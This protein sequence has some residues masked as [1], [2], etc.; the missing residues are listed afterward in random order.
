MISLSN[1]A[2]QYGGQVLFDDASFQLNPGDKAGLVGPNGSGKTT[3]FRLIMGEEE[4]T[5]GAVSRPKKLTVGYF[6]QDVGD[7]AGRSVLAETVAGAGELADLGEELGRLEGRM[8]EA[9]D[10][11]DAVI[12]RYGEVQSRFEELGGYELESRARSILAGLGLKD[13]QVDEDIGRLSGGWKMRVALARILL[14]QPDALLLDEPT[15]YLDLESILWFEGFLRDYR[16]AVLMTCHDRD[17][18]NRVVSRIVEIDGGEIT[19]YTGDYDFY[20]R[21]RLQELARREAQ[22]GRQ[23]AMLAKERRFIE[24][25]QAQAAKAAQVQ[26]RVK[27]LDKIEKVEP[28]RRIVESTFQFPPPARSGDDVVKIEGLRKVYGERVVHASREPSRLDPAGSLDWSALRWRHARIHERADGHPRLRRVGQGQVGR[29]PRRPARGD[30]LHRPDRPRCGQR[31]CDLQTAPRVHAGDDGAAL[32]RQSE[33]GRV[34]HLGAAR[35][36]VG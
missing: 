28:P 26:S 14:A 12:E 13:E 6:R 32:Q 19:S 36:V 29:Q 9:G 8:A 15:N 17:V 35:V 3:I 7:A 34:G 22:Y 5:A 4:P 11:L 23:Q 25:F 27:K 30:R 10:D 20:E 18:M 1:L 33:R 31:L 16:G 2:V 21:A 24:R